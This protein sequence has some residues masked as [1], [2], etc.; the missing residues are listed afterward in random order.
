MQGDT[1]SYSRLQAQDQES[2]LELPPWSLRPPTQEAGPAQGTYSSRSL[3]AL[4]TR[5]GPLLGL[6]DPWTALLEGKAWSQ[7]SRGEARASGSNLAQP[8]S[9]LTSELPLPQHRGQ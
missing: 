5:P 1:R 2:C 4:P 3:V 9:C 8:H 7:G 6:Q